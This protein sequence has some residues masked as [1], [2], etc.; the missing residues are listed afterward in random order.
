MSVA[1][2]CTGFSLYKFFAPNTVQLCCMQET[3]VHVTK[4]ERSDWS[5][6]NGVN[7]VAVIV[8]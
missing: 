6:Y 5:L 7:K 8:A 3:C 2:S 1:V 4:I